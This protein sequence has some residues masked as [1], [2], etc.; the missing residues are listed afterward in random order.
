MNKDTVVGILG[1]VIL[2]A[3]MVGIFYYEGTQAPGGGTT[4]GG[5]GPGGPGGLN[6][7]T[8]DGPT[9]QGAAGET[10]APKTL[11]IT[12]VNLTQVELIVTWTNPQTGNQAFTVAATSPSGTALSDTSNTGM[13]SVVFSPLSQ[14]SAQTSLN[15]TG[16]WTVEVTPGASANPACAGVGPLPLPGNPCAP[17]AWS[18]TT[19]LSYYRAT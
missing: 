9:A 14:P 11:N 2:V 17:P 6:V 10:P 7:T 19:R 18:L 12:Q 1:A 5:P 4:P 13:A 16:T 8:V 15:G 3:A